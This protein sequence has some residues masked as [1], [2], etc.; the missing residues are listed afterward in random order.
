M[1]RFRKSYSKSYSEDYII[2]LKNYNFNKG[3]YKYV[4]YS[5][6]FQKKYIFV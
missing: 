3:I 2:Y 5:I 6:L 1:F 4:Y